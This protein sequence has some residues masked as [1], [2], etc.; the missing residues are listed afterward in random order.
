[1]CFNLTCLVLLEE[2]EV[3]L[4]AGEK[5]SADS[6][7]FLKGPRGRR[8]CVTESSI[9]FISPRTDD[10][11][12]PEQKRVQELCLCLAADTGKFGVF[13]WNWGAEGE[14]GREIFSSELEKNWG[15][16]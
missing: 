4:L 9:H 10:F 6:C 1:M 7:A 16:L 13:G 11:N 15:K 14:W 2:K 12:L 3:Q 5:V 8:H